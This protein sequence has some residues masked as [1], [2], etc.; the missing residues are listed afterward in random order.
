MMES[1][2]ANLGSHQFVS[3]TLEPV[4]GHFEAKAD[5]FGSCFSWMK[6]K[7]QS[8]AVDQVTQNIQV[9]SCSVEG[10]MSLSLGRCLLE[11]LESNA[12]NGLAEGGM[13]SHKL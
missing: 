8:L 5:E 4:P 2:L 7:A 1:P 12:P 3:S 11:V 13:G 9:K 6:T 10:R